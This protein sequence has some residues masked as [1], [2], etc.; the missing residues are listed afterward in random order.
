M[1]DVPVTFNLGPAAYEALR[2]EARRAGL[3]EQELLTRI[4][5][6][7]LGLDVP[8]E[9]WRHQTELSEEEAIEIATEELRAHREER[10]QA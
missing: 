7:H 5:R 9:R 8:D 6:M 2:R 3:E 1:A 4:V 10:R